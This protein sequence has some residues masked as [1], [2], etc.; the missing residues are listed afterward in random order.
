MARF[1]F[2]CV[3][4]GCGAE[5][6][7]PS[8]NPTTPGTT[9]VPTTTPTTTPTPTTEVCFEVDID[10]GDPPAVPDCALPAPCPGVAFSDDAFMPCYV[11]PSTFDPT[12]AACVTDALATGQP[13]VFTLT[14]CPGGQ[15]SEIWQIQSLGDGTALW[16]NWT[17]EDMGG[18]GYATW[19]SLPDPGHFQACTTDTAQDL[20][21]CLSEITSQPCIHGEPTC[22]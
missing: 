14:N 3:L 22:P 7:V 19:R 13:G 17:Y 11:P 15:Y 16:H 9:S 21:D 2:L 4:L 12:A 20:L 18:R 1:L 8:T 10:Y 6:P 5:D